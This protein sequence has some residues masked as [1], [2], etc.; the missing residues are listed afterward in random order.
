MPLSMLTD[1]IPA[2]IRP[3]PNTPR[4]LYFNV[5]FVKKINKFRVFKAKIL[6]KEIITIETVT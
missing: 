6:T 4:F 5:F 2:P 1:A 3:A